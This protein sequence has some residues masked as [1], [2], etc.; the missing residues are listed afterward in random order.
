[1]HENAKMPAGCYWDLQPC[2]TMS[3]LGHLRQ[4]PM[5]TW[6]KVK[7]DELINHFP[8]EGINVVVVGGANAYWRIMGARYRKTVQSTRGARPKAA[9]YRRAAMPAAC[10]RRPHHARWP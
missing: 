10:C 8:A 6:L 4:E 1:M 2:R 9:G 7:P 5:A 3:S